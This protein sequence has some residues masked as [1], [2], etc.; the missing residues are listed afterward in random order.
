MSNRRQFI[1]MLGGAVAWP[2]AARAQQAERM[3][4]IRV[5][6]ALA[7]ND[8]FM[9]AR[10][11]AFRQTLEGLGW[12]EGRNIHMDY[13]FAAAQVDQFEV[14]ARELV[15]LQPDVIWHRPL[16]SPPL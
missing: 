9:K 14:I 11:A 8:A 10:L 2:L 13:R 1:T 4:R 6:V 12:S 15:A 3:R 5:L 16:Q 7:E